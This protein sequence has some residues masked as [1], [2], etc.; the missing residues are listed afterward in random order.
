MIQIQLIPAHT[1]AAVERL[2]GIGTPDDAPDTG[3]FE[4]MVIGGSDVH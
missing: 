1:L 3:R 2:A 4:S